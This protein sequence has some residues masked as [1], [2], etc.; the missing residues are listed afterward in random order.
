MGTTKEQ[1]RRRALRREVQSPERSEA[2][3]RVDRYALERSRRD[4]V[5]AV[6]AG[7]VLG[8]IVVTV[9]V[10]IVSVLV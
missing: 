6:I 1:R 8:M 4:T 7:S 9:V 3:M 5:V 10:A 2:L